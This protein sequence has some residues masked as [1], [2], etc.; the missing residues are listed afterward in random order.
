MP[1]Q[2]NITRFSGF[3]DCYDAA[4]PQPPAIAIDILTQ[5]AQTLRP[6]L[7]VD[8]G[9]GTGLSTRIWAERAERIIGIE[10]ND[11]MRA[12]AARATAAGNVTYQKGF[13]SQTNLP[14]NCAD[15]VTCSQSL[16]WMEPEPTFREIH[17]ILRTGGLFAAI[18]CDWPPTIG[19]EI[20]QTYIAF[21]RHVD[22]LEKQHGITESIYRWPKHEHLRRITESGR[23]RF[24]K[25]ILVHSVEQGN[26]DRL[27]QLVNSLGSVATLLKMGISEDEIGLTT[28]RAA[29]QKFIGHAPRP[30]YF[31]YRIRIGMK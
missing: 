25:E 22:A 28:L 12:Q 15:I 13:S 23:F 17:R 16:H 14:D 21:N 30:W 20:E 9:C 1:H 18:D 29:A 11:D 26:D 4:R 31:S 5:L 3:A 2:P 6:K 10:P 27:L 24:T 7:V 8:I 19:S